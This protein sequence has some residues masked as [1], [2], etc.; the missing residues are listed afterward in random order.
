MIEGLETVAGKYSLKR[1]LGGGS[2]GEV[3]EA[4][5]NETGGAYAIKVEK[6]ETKSPQLIGEAKLLRSL[7]ATGI[8][9]VYWHGTQDRY[10]VMVMELLGPS[11]ED[12][13]KKCRRQLSLKTV[14]QI[15]DQLIQRIYNL[16]NNH[17]I[18]R[19]IKAEN[20][21]VG[22]G[23]KKDLLYLID[24]GLSKRFREPKTKQHIPYRENR[25]LT[26]TARYASVNTH[27][28][29]EQSRRDDLESAA[30][31][32]IY[33]SRGSLPWQGVQGITK[34]EKYIKIMDMKM[35]TPILQL[36]KGLPSQFADFL[37]YCRSLRFEDSPNY[38]KI[39]NFFLEAA[40][41]MSIVLDK[42]FDWSSQK[43]SWRSK[44]TASSQRTRSKNTRKRVKS[45]GKKSKNIN[46]ISL[47]ET[48][49]DKTMPAFKDGQRIRLEICKS[50][51]F[52]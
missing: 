50:T 33:L 13:F 1:R 6:I 27:L 17:Y 46:D 7:Q 41:N 4:V 32:I 48:F 38:A 45:A 25:S 30:Y 11:L 19:D 31:L 2:F 9:R 23:D 42:Q 16:H 29:I 34:Q 18:H 28:G 40:S 51:N 5:H 3:Y 8:P 12:L 52:M 24:F 47:A 14:L 21:T 43:K 10:N 22:T 36:C 15:G 44:T 20:F 37:S 39:R 26:G 49:E 35:S